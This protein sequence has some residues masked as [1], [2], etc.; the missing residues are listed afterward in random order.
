[1]YQGYKNYL[2]TPGKTTYQKIH[3]QGII[4]RRMLPLLLMLSMSI[5]ISCVSKMV[6][7]IDLFGKKTNMVQDALKNPSFKW[8]AMK[9]EHFD[10]HYIFTIWPVGTIDSL[11]VLLEGFYKRNCEL[12]GASE[13]SARHD[14]FFVGS[15]TQVKEITGQEVAA[16]PLLPERG[17]VFSNTGT[18]TMPQILQHELMHSMSFDIWGIPK[19]FLM[20]EGLATFAY[21]RSICDFNFDPI[22]KY[23]L[24]KKLV[25]SIK[26]LSETD[27]F[28]YDEVAKYSA[29]ASFVDMVKT[30]YGTDG[31]KRLWTLGIEKGLLDF[32]MTFKQFDKEYL[33]RVNSV[34]TISE[35][36]W[37]L[38]Q[39][40]CGK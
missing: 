22:T 39:K 26:M 10:I 3:Y 36:D 20:A 4:M 37:R 12:L 16:S 5:A 13:Y 21:G 30:K 23:V 34:M 6:R 14:I 33:L 11:S 38:L 9:T 40:G 29:A 35:D 7:P 32:G 28:T 17:C 27:W 19:E 2:E 25:P 15:K 31:I 8:E 24:Q 1:M 18:A